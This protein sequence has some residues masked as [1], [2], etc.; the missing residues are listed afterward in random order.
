MRYFIL[1]VALLLDP[2]AVL[3]LPGGALREAV[4]LRVPCPSTPAPNVT[5]CR[6]CYMPPTRMLTGFLMI[7]AVLCV[8]FV[9]LLAWAPHIWWH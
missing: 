9:L 1:V 8:V 7:L 4:D 5:A 2:A 3:L 6:R